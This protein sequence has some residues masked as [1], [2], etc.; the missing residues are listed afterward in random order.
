VGDVHLLD[1][2][3]FAPVGPLA[4]AGSDFA[5]RAAGWVEGAMASG[6]GAAAAL[7]DRAARLTTG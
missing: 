4:F 3:R 6:T 1:A 7:L 2:D 5:P